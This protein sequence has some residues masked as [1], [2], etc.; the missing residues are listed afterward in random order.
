MLEKVD[1][2][3]A[4]TKEQ[5]EPKLKKLQERLRI[6]QQAALQA[7]IAVSLVLEGWDSAGKGTLVSR[8][9]V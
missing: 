7:P 2:S 3:R 6:L 5:A 4:L 9:S 8:R 1:L